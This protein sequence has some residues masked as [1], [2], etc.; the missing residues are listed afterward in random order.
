M[1]LFRLVACLVLA[2]VFLAGC[3]I[4][5]RREA[6][7]KRAED[8]AK[9]EAAKKVIAEKSTTIWKESMDKKKDQGP[10]SGSIS[11]GDKSLTFT[12]ASIV[13]GALKIPG[14]PAGGMEPSSLKCSSANGV[15]LVIPAILLENGAS[16]P[17]QLA[18]QSFDLNE[19]N[20]TGAEI[21]TEDGAKWNIKSAL[22]TFSRADRNLVTLSI[23]GNAVDASGQ[24]TDKLKINGEIQA[25]IGGTDGQPINYD[26]KQT[27]P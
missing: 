4:K 17:E 13:L 1:K 2:A 26:P 19:S 11:L 8:K 20:N 5:E 14:D 21:T 6:E 24:K 12:Q 23:E 15:A 10:G 7:K 22:I 16:R 25:R 9:A 27:N 3:G 18:G